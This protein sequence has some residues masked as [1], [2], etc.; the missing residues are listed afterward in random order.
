M[1]IKTRRTLFYCLTALF[2]ILGTLTVLYSRG[3]RLDHGGFGIIR[4]G[5]IYISSQ[6]EGASIFLDGKKQENKSGILQRGT[7]ISNLLPGDHELLVSQ[8]GYLD[9]KKNTVVKSGE[10]SVFDSV[11]LLSNAEAQV[12]RAGRFENFDFINGHLVL[13]SSA[14]ITLDE[15]TVR[16]DEIVSLTDSGSLIT[17]D[18]N[19]NSFYLTSNLTPEDSLDLTAL[20]NNLKE[21]RLEL[22]G[23][24]Q[25]L[26]ILLA[27]N[28]DR[29][30]YVITKRAIYLMDV[31]KP[32]LELLALDYA[33]LNHQ[34]DN[35]LIWTKEGVVY[36][37][38]PTFH[39]QGQP[40]VLEGTGINEPELARI[41]KFNDGWLFLDK[42]GELKYYTNILEL[43]ATGVSAFELSSADNRIAIIKSGG[44]LYIR[45]FDT[46]VEI[47]G[48]GKG[49][50]QV[51][52][53]KDAA[54]VFVLEGQQLYFRDITRDMPI[55]SH[56]LADGV[57]EFIYDREEQFVL[58]LTDEG[59]MKIPL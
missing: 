9:W 29:W 34:R 10:V 46:G 19:T 58:T 4:T 18:N 47:N 1:S 53:Y 28:N 21:N 7:L 5:G 57:P 32:D 20:F 3:I 23:Y 22:S 43:L 12:F 52:W 39:N 30:L 16:G 59:I 50:N 24:V 41:A 33:N 51:G 26:Q 35:I 15:A 2:L 37:F 55:N 25:P 48:L 8:E 11:V 54:H 17:R 44:E 31:R 42:T 14:G 56:K 45:D 36:N 6:P 49:V 13:E 27:S 40:L 38:N